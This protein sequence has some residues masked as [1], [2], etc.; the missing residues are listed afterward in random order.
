VILL[1]THAWI[2]WVNDPKKLSKK[3]RETINDAAKN[4]GFYISSFSSWELGMLVNKGRLMLDRDIS[5]WVAASEALPFINFVPINNRIALKSI[6]LDLHPDPADRIIVATALSLGA[7]MVTKDEKLRSF[8]L[9]ETI[10]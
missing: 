3:A 9:L 1:D 5:D 7:S 2:W 4:E 6:E 8:K 10:W